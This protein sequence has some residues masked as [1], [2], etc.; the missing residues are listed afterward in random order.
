MDTMDTQAATEDP[1][2]AGIDL[3]KAAMPQTY[4]AI[5]AKGQEIGG[6][7]FAL[8]RRGLRGE[9]NCFWACERGNVVGTPFS[10]DKGIMAD[11]A[12]AM[13]TFGCTFVAVWPRGNDGA[14]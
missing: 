2:K 9:A 1:A 10:E 11:V 14:H 12:K 3:I 8:V 6:E 5:Q 4:K 13:V 7:A